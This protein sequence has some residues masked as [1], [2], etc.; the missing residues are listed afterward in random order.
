[1]EA[2]KDLINYIVPVLLGVLMFASNFLNTELFEFGANNFA[3][4]FVLSFLCFGC[5]WYIDKTLG[6]KFGGKVVFATVVAATFVGIL[7]ISSFREFFGA[8]NLL[9][10]NLILYSLRSVT[11]GAMGIFGMSV[12]EILFKQKNFDVLEERL[13][14]Y[15][16]TVKDAKKEAEIEIRDAKV[17][18]QKIIADAEAGAK[19]II[20][21]K[22]RIE[23]ELKEF[24][25][26]E[27]EL[28]KRYEDVG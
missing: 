12:A 23:K 26:A 25:Q 21:K 18:A 16:E 17:K 7:M 28:I 19:N 13:K 2:K 22:E 5:G 1:M 27:K 11:L 8:S 14:V 3:V 10:E 20:L 9:T 6:W 24:I 4:W 15:Q